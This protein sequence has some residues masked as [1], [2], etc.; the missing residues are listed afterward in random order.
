MTEPAHVPATGLGPAT[1][2]GVRQLASS[3][4]PLTVALVLLGAWQAI[5]GL[6]W[7]SFRY[8]PAPWSIVGAGATAIDNG[9]VW[10]PLW[11]TVQNVLWSWALALAVGITL[12]LLVGVSRTADRFTSTTIEILRPLP[13]IGF[14]PVAVVIFGLSSTV[15]IVVGAFAATWPALTN[16]AGA[17]RNVNP[18]LH[19]VG[20]V[21]SFSRLRTALRI[22]FPAALPSM[23]VGIRLSLG[24][25]LVAVVATEMVGVPQGIGYAII[26][27]QQS[28]HPAE[29]FFY[30]ALAGVLGALLNVFVIRAG[31]LLMP[32]SRVRTAP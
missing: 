3:A 14:I 28:L 6:G 20:Q 4:S 7:L 2:R 12:G 5:I 21:F 11:H 26:Q 30:I 24:I 22:V 17:V 18:I 19:E 15:E 9:T 1:G 25:A 32:G 23:L 13:A 31:A 10:D 27:A 8:L 16:T 29:M